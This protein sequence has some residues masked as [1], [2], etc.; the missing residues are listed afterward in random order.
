MCGYSERMAIYASERKTWPDIES[1][2]L[3]KLDFILDFLVPRTVR[4]KFLLFISHMICGISV[5]AAQGDWNIHHLY[6]IF[7]YE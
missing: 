4:N 1:A 7:E 2:S 3:Q 5:T 6:K